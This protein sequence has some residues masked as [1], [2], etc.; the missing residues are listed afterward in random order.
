MYRKTGGSVFFFRSG[1]VF[2]RFQNGEQLRICDKYYGRIAL[3][4][5]IVRS[6]FILFV[7]LL[8]I[9]ILLS[10]SL[11]MIS[12]VLPNSCSSTVHFIILAFIGKTSKTS[13]AGEFLSGTAIVVFSPLLIRMKSDFEVPRQDDFSLYFP[14]CIEKMLEFLAA[15]PFQMLVRWDVDWYSGQRI[16]SM[17]YFNSDYFYRVKGPKLA[18]PPHPSVLRIELKMYPLSIILT[19]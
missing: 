7:V 11:Q 2:S 16:K 13:M 9:W 3:M 15:F 6:L 5:V 4:L 14:Y 8:E 19:V 17:F 12:W 18:L 1:M 10:T